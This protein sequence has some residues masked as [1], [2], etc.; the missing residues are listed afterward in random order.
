M[1]S[2]FYVF[3]HFYMANIVRHVKVS[4]GNLSMII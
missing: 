1:R 2:R 4:I 3:R